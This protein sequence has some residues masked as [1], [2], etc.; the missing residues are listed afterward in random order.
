MLKKQRNTLPG[1]GQAKTGHKPCRHLQ[2]FLPHSSCSCL[3]NWGTGPLYVELPDLLAFH[4]EKEVHPSNLTGIL[5][6]GS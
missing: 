3:S 2:L 4:G 5:H 6:T 1:M